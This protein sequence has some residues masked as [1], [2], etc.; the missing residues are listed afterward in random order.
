MPNDSEN[1]EVSV[2]SRA[3]ESKREGT[4]TSARFNILSTMVGGGSLSL[5]LAFYQAGN[6]LTAPL[7]LVAIAFLV[8]YS[9]HF[10]LQASLIVFPPKEHKGIA[11]FEGVAEAAFG[12]RA[13]Y[14]CRMLLSVICFFS[15]VGYA[16]LLKDTIEPLSDFIFGNNS[17]TSR[18][19]HNITMII[20]ILVITPLC[21]LQDLT[22]LQKVGKLSMTS[23][24]ILA[25][26]IS[27]RSFQCNFQDE[28]TDIRKSS[29]WE[30]MTYTPMDY[31]HSEGTFKAL[32][33]NITN[34]LPILLSV[35]MCHFNVLPV[36][37]ELQ[38]PM[39]NQRLKRLFSSCIWGAALFYIFVG[40]SGS[41]YGNC[42]EDGVVDGN[43]LLSFDA[44]DK[45]LGIGRACLSLTIICA[46]PVL[47]VPCRDIVLRAWVETR[48]LEVNGESTDMEHVSG[49]ESP[50]QPTED[51]QL[52]EPLLASNEQEQD[53][54]LSHEDGNTAIGDCF[55]IMSS[56]LILW[57]AA[58]LACFV[59]SIDI[60]WDIL[61]GSFSLMMGFLIPAGSFL[62]LK[63]KRQS[64]TVHS[65]EDSGLEQLENANSNCTDATARGSD[66]NKAT[67]ILILIVPVMIILTSNV[68]YKFAN[69][70]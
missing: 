54:V 29:P 50:Y 41:M 52:M 18:T 8:Q 20:F 51:N 27:Y 53:I 47:V 66:E 43:I 44:D 62:V 32:W 10:L 25:S 38:R 60:V 56:I 69:T 59:T 21:T 9:I 11:S 30:Y 2:S 1:N 15:V 49:N 67:L 36:V 17:M 26:I 14:F 63:K 40:I 37:N 58:G 22:P 19:R 46:F 34:A 33:G 24:T 12:V 4:L 28:Y 6:V 65:D 68:I 61:G 42:V 5:P 57:F 39:E 31:L 7:L 16:V 35:F 23:L 55:R 13:K 45:L 3:D 64:F 48:A 70:E